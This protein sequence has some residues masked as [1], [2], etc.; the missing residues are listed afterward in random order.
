MDNAFPI[1]DAVYLVRV[2]QCHTI[3]GRDKDDKHSEITDEKP[4]QLW[5]RDNNI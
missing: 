1:R 3:Y 4:H 5:R 2:E